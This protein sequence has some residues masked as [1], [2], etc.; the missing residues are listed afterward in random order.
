ML[1]W[2]NIKNVMYVLFFSWDILFIYKNFKFIQMESSLWHS[3]TH[4]KHTF[5]P[6]E[7]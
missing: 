3:V 5:Y 6:A 2:H 1:S 4:L 7:S